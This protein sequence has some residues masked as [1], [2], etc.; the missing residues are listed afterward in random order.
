MI[1]VENPLVLEHQLS[2][3]TIHIL[4]KL[5]RWS[6]LGVLQKR[7][8]W[9]IGENPLH[10]ALQAKIARKLKRIGLDLY[11]G[12]D[13]S[14][15]RN[16]LLAYRYV[17][18]HNDIGLKLTH[19]T[20]FIPLDIPSWEARFLGAS[21]DKKYHDLPIKEGSIV[22][23]DQNKDHKITFNED[24]EGDIKFWIALFLDKAPTHP[25]STPASH[26]IG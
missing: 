8:W 6:A 17:N 20:I 24:D 25:D 10:L 4:H 23:F 26:E 19:S 5:I 11:M 7:P 1:K 14:W 12:S 16:A 22:V 21:A 9:L 13:G 3:R 18:L 2:E 15:D